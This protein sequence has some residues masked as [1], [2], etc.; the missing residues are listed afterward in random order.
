MRAIIAFAFLLAIPAASAQGCSAE[1]PCIWV[2]DVDDGGFDKSVTTS[3]AGTLGDWVVLEL[4]N[5]G[6][7]EHTIRFDAYGLSWSVGSLEFPTTDPFELAEAG[8]F[9]LV[10]DPSGDTFPVLVT[11][12][13]AVDV[14]QGDPAQ[15]K[16]TLPD[17]GAPGPAIGLLLAGLA[18][19][20]MRRR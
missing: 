12:N 15:T 1:E 13:D 5:F 2:V 6:D 11:V 9:A 8:E 7:S 3:H 20:A 4:S 19:V 16:T 10:D 18:L 17:E 14:E